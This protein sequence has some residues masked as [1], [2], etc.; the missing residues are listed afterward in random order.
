[1]LRPRSTYRDPFHVERTLMIGTIS[2]WVTEIGT[3]YNPCLLIYNREGNKQ[4]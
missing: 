3:T 4:T 2:E 1:M